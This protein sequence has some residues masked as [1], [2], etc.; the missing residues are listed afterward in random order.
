MA[1][2]SDEDGH[3]LD[4]YLARAAKR[5]RREEPEP[6]GDEPSS[7]GDVL[8]DSDDDEREGG[9][10]EEVDY[11]HSG[12]EEEQGQERVSGDVSGGSDD[13]ESADDEP[14]AAELDGGSDGGSGSDGEGDEEDE[15]EHGAGGSGGSSPR[16]GAACAQEE[17]GQPQQQGAAVDGKGDAPGNEKAPQQKI[18]VIRPPVKPPTGVRIVDNTAEIVRDHEMVRLLRNPRY[19]D[20]FQEEPNTFRCFNCGQVGSGAG[21][22]AGG[23]GPDAAGGSDGGWRHSHAVLAPSVACWHIDDIVHGGC[24]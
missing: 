15:E 21:G 1:S 16:A 8:E 24:Q 17:P 14:G 9:E 7:E 18:L 11:G 20:D 5:S 4:D 2:D 3:P 12:D 22:K 13:D 10:E 23:R 6:A 19:F